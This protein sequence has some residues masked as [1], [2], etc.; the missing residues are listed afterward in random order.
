MFVQ[1][2]LDEGAVGPNL[3]PLL[4]KVVVKKAREQLR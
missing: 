1:T 3:N 4:S 2:V